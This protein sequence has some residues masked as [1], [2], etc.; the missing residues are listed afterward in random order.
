MLT[1]CDV[2]ARITHIAPLQQFGRSCGIQILSHHLPGRLGPV[3]RPLD[4]LIAIYVLTDFLH[5][6]ILEIM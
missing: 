5:F 4:L 2:F 1:E 6:P 3:V